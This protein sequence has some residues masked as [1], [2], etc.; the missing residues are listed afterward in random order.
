MMTLGFFSVAVLMAAITLQLALG[1]RLDGWLGIAFGATG[2]AYCYLATPS[3]GL[4]PVFFASSVVL[5]YGGVGSAVKLW[6]RR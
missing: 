3:W 4:I 6:R 5:L 2:I 1:S